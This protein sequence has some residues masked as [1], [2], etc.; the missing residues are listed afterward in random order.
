MTQRR[1]EKPTISIQEHMAIDVCPGP[2]QPIKQISDYFPRYPRGFPPTAAPVLRR[3]GSLRSSTSSSSSTPAA[4]TSSLG[5]ETGQEKND[6]EDDLDRAFSTASA[7][8]SASA[9]PPPS[10]K[11]EEPDMEGYD[12]D[13]S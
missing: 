5:A 13:D 8:A 4:A 1:G 10:R 2:I 3:A 6:N 7:S 12:S 11:E 9:L